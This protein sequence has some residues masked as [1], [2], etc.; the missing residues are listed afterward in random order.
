MDLTD[1]QNDSAYFTAFEMFE[2]LVTL[3]LLNPWLKSFEDFKKIFT[4]E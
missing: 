1:L 3:F 4:T 2:N